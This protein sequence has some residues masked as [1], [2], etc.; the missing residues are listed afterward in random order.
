MINAEDIGCILEG[1]GGC[2]NA[3]YMVLFDDFQGDMVSQLN[4]GKAGCN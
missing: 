3:P 2:D 1:F 4:R